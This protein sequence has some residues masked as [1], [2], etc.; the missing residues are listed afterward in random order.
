MKVKISLKYAILC[1]A[2]VASGNAWAIV[3]MF[4]INIT[5]KSDN[6]IKVWWTKSDLNDETALSPNNQV[7][8]DNTVTIKKGA[9]KKFTEYDRTNQKNNIYAGRRMVVDIDGELFTQII[10]EGIN[11]VEIRNIIQAKKSGNETDEITIFNAL[12]E[13]ITVSWKKK[14]SDKGTTDPVSI[15]K[16]TELSGRF[17]KIGRSNVR[18][19]IV[20]GRFLV[21]KTTRREFSK[22]I[23][24]GDNSV[25]IQNP[26]EIKG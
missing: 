26:I 9:T 14:T 8:T 11:K 10:P 25:I 1:A 20:D 7:R 17:D 23:K 4:D 16:N 24:K 6:P 22:D 18:N 3:K 19:K 12:T 15:A 21:V 13:P 2:I 5:N